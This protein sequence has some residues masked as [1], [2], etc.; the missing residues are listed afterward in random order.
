MTTRWE[1][2]A[3]LERDV[4]R[5]ERMYVRSSSFARG[6]FLVTCPRCPGV[7]ANPPQPK[8][9]YADTIE[10]ATTTADLHARVKHPTRAQP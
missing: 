8:A 3:T 10:E 9:W 7:F 2:P 6:K 1:N 5:R 4:R